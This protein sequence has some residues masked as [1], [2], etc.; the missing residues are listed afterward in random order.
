MS[1]AILQTICCSRSHPGPDEIVRRVVEYLFPQI[2]TADELVTLMEQR[3]ESEAITGGFAWASR[4]IAA[5]IDPWSGPAV[6]F[7]DK[8]ADLIWHERTPIKQVYP[9]HSRFDHLAEALARLCDRQV[10]EEPHRHLDG[11]LIRACVIASLFD[12]GGNN[13][14][15]TFENL[16]AHFKNNVT[17]RSVAFWIELACIDEDMPHRNDR[18]RLENMLENSLAGRLTEIDQSW[19]ETAIEDVSRPERRGVALHAWIHIWREIGRDASKLD[20]IRSMLKDDPALEQG[21][22]A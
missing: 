1:F 18:D 9:I 20:T 15:K 17:L 12:S 7:R 22:S 16:R 2:I 13:W 4:G 8:M 3:P 6:A 11:D 5:I 19:L 21:V 14:R 10:S